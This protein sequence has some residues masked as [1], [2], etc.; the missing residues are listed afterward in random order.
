VTRRLIARPQVVRLLNERWRHRAVVLTAGPGFGKSVALAEAVAE[1]AMAPRGA[2]VLVEC[3]PGDHRPG[4]LLRRIAAAAGVDM[5]RALPADAVTWLLGRIARRWPREACLLLDDAH[6]ADEATIA[7]LVREAPASLHL[8]LAA[9]HRLGGLARARADGEV[10]DIGEDDLRFDDAELAELAAGHGVA[11]DVVAGV[12]GWPAGAAMAA[13]YGARGAE[14]YLFETA[15]ARLDGAHRRLLAIALAIGGGDEE[16]LRAAAGPTFPSPAVALAG[17][18]L[19]RRTDA[20]ELVVHDLWAGLVRGDLAAA[21]IDAAVQRAVPVLVE[22]TAFDRAFRLCADRTDWDG[23][24]GVVRAVCR[25]GHA[26]VALDVAEGWLA[27]L[28]ADRRER[29]EGLLLRGLVG[30]IHDPFGPAT[31]DVLRRAVDAF[32]AAGDVGGQIAAGVELVYVLRNQGR[33]EGIVDFV[34]RAIELDER[35]HPE[36]AGPAAVGRALCAE[37]AGDDAEMVAR[38]DAVPAGALSRDWQLTATFRLAM[39]HLVLGNEGPMLEAAERC[40]ELA[41]GGTDRHIVALARWFAGDPEPAL[42]TLAEIDADARRSGTGRVMLGALAVAAAASGGQQCHAVRL[43]GALEEA[44]AG[45]L[46]A[47]LEGAVIAARSLVAAAGGDDVAARAVLTDA[48]A[49]APLADGTGWRRAVRWLPL[50]YVLVPAARREITAVERGA[51]HRRRLDAARAV[52]WAREGVGPCPPALA[53]ATAPALCTSVPLPWVAEVAARLAAEGSPH[54]ARLAGELLDRFGE[55]AR[56]ALRAAATHAAKPIARGAKALLGAVAAP[57]ATRVIRLSILGPTLLDV[58]ATAAGPHWNRER[59]RSLLVFLALRRAAGRDDVVD[60]LWAHLTP[61]AA[62]RN[63]RVTLC[64]LQQVLEP[65]R[66]NGEAPFFVRQEGSTLALAP[67]PFVRTDADEFDALVREALD[68]DDHGVRT[69]AVERF[70]AAIALWRGPCLVDVAF[71]DWAQDPS[72]QLTSRFVRS[73]IR[74]GQLHLGAGRVDDA[75]RCAD[76]ALAVDSW[77]ESAHRLR[78]AAALERGDRGRAARELAA[79]DE[80]L[81]ELGVIADERTEALR[82]ELRR[83]GRRWTAEWLAACA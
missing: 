79:C 55:P 9:H 78:I 16:L 2:D 76:R 65:E 54:G 62:E 68:A 3:T 28:P 67:A 4:S 63:L 73:A 61:E 30:R 64:Y 80:M 25:R 70:E 45:P 50:A 58:G 27:A 49:A 22:R 12:D 75:I 71:E 7:A 42:A 37:L 29:P 81:A 20:D 52:V 34:A 14:E 59:V 48:L 74:A 5:P 6:H 72:R 8:V 43:L 53:A 10:V 44:A 33:T 41:V 66:R 24:T 46:S 17:L 18:P 13:S 31:P 82:Q 77:S 60:A 38:L 47:L 40:A 21:D 11:S 57:P 39:G 19:V 15:G 35:G 51:L 26:N 1:N 69:V 83:N 23:A 36:A 56:A 32:A